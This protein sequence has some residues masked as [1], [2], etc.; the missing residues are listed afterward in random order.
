MRDMVASHDMVAS[1]ELPKGVVVI[2]LS[3]DSIERQAKFA[4]KSSVDYPL[5]ADVDHKVADKY[6]AWG[7]KKLLSLIHI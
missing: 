7:P 4:D 3:P 6:G 1:S 5:L 2:G